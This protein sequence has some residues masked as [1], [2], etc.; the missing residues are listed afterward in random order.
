MSFVLISGPGDT[1]LEISGSLGVGLATE[2]DFRAF[3]QWSG[4]PGIL[5]VLGQM[6]DDEFVDGFPIRAGVDLDAEFLVLEELHGGQRHRLERVESLLETFGVVVLAPRVLCATK[7]PL[8][9]HRIRTFEV[10]HLRQ[11]ALFSKGIMPGL[12]IRE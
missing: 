12:E 6:L 11:F 4:G 1:S 2:Q 10:K 9:E 7:Y 8:F 3:A 5:G